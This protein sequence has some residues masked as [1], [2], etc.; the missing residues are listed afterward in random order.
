[1]DNEVLEAK[2]TQSQD[3]VAAEKAVNDVNDVNGCTA[4]NTTESSTTSGDRVNDAPSNKSDGVEN[5]SDDESPPA[6][7][8]AP[9]DTDNAEPVP[10]SDDNYQ[11][12]DRR[13]EMGASDS[14]VMSDYS[15]EKADKEKRSHDDRELEPSSPARSI[16]SGGNRN[17]AYESAD[18]SFDKDDRSDGSS[19]G[20]EYLQF[21]NLF[22]TTAIQELYQLTDFV[23][24][25][26]LFLFLRLGE[27][28]MLS[29][30]DERHDMDRERMND[31]YDEDDYHSS[32]TMDDGRDEE[33]VIHSID[34]SDSEDG[35]IEDNQ[36]GH[37]DRIM[38]MKREIDTKSNGSYDDDEEDEDDDGD[39][40]DDIES[41]SGDERDDEKASY[42]H[43]S[44]NNSTN[45]YTNH[46]NSSNS[47]VRHYL[48]TQLNK[49]GFKKL[50]RYQAVKR[51]VKWY[52]KRYFLISKFKLGFCS[53]RQ[54]FFRH[55]HGID[56][57][58]CYNHTCVLLIHFMNTMNYSV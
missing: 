10:K 51:S 46:T 2:K 41:D 8:R 36:G 7:E 47:K 35:Y 23:C 24:A 29:E 53:C 34:D 13:L 57:D 26:R 1:M 12:P 19:I 11:S 21:G 6:T 9:N 14:D 32:S 28:D 5:I 20:S 49:E 40:G 45:N 18:D 16:D 55:L 38:D 50:H 52:V 43:P 15:P 42:H 33:N 56:I 25:V 3:D 48:K 54:H 37:Y 4:N 39:D 30:D 27:E 44:N 17:S 58:T 31:E 22:G